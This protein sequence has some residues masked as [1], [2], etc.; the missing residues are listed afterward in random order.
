MSLYGGTTDSTDLAWILPDMSSGILWGCGALILVSGIFLT[1]SGAGGGAVF[2]TILASLGGLTAHQAIPLSKFL[3]LTA[4][5]VVFLFNTVFKGKTNFIDF[6]IVRSIVPMCLAGTLIG[7]LVNTLVSD[8]V[9]M[10]LLTVI[11]LLIL[12]KTSK[13]TYDKW[14]TR[15]LDVVAQSSGT[16]SG[17]VEAVA[18]GD[19]P[20]LP[21]RVADSRRKNFVMAG[22]IPLI[23]I[24]GVFAKL[25]SVPTA[26]VVILYAI[27]ICACIAVTI[28]FTRTASSANPSFSLESFTYVIIGFIG[29][30][31][32]GLFGIGGGLLYAPFLLHKGVEPAVA[33]AVSSTIVLFASVS[34][35]FQYIF[36]DRVAIVVGL[37]LS[38]FTVMAGFI[39]VWL[40]RFIAK[41]PERQIN[42]YFLVLVAAATSAVLAI[43]KAVQS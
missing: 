5:I 35:A 39:A 42:V 26:V 29:G 43:I 11:L 18:Q 34:A 10:I 19:D 6:K 25:S 37:V 16:N 36:L 21:H 31:I 32:S 12:L 28:W 14:K 38:I 33:V 23:V 13:M 40:I 7:V 1:A 30:V 2:V 4:S 27:P 24:C 8:R 20:L 17:S 41:K 3:T 22:L 9:L 15:N